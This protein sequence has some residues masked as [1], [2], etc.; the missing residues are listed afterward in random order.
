MRTVMPAE[1]TA[2]KQRGRPFPKGQSGNP[3]GRPVGARNQAT[4][5]AEA[6]L[7]G[8]AEKLT[9][10]AVVLAL[11]GNVACLRLCLDRILAPRRERS[12]QFPFPALNSV[13]DASQAMAGIAGAVGRGE[14]TPVEAAQLSHIVETY[15]RV[16]ETT[17]I[18]RRL[19]VLEERQLARREE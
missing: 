14:L 7:D 19:Q 16:I 3:N 18:E 1:T 8:E 11:R 9:R 17:E 13:V 2:P 4:L 10:K 12:A 6:L 5:A 15:V